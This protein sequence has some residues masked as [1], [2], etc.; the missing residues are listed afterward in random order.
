MRDCNI[1]RKLRNSLGPVRT[2]L[3]DVASADDV[4]IAEFRTNFEKF[5]PVKTLKDK[6]GF[7]RRECPKCGNMYWRKSKEREVC[8]CACVFICGRLLLRADLIV[9]N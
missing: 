2:C 4:V 5:Y 7:E 8:A 1:C 3:R 9:V 6:L